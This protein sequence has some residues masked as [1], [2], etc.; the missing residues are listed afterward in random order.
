[1]SRRLAVHA[2]RGKKKI[3]VREEKK[4]GEALSYY[5]QSCMNLPKT[6][7]EEKNREALLAR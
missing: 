6:R 2:G 4:K 1:M 7:K 5:N 3:S